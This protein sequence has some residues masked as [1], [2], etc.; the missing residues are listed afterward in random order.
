LSAASDDPCDGDSAHSL[1]PYALSELRTTATDVSVTRPPGRET[2]LIDVLSAVGKSRGTG[3]VTAPV[4]VL[5]I[6]GR[7][8]GLLILDARA[9]ST[10]FTT[11]DG[12]ERALPEGWRLVEVGV[13]DPGLRK[14][15]DGMVGG[16]E[17]Q[18]LFKA[19]PG[20]L[21]QVHFRFEHA[22]SD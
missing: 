14:A 3:I 19:R 1:L 17:R 8:P 20:H 5:E 9:A 18:A 12:I 4:A 15:I 6:D 10:L 13:T 7:L 2:H 11:V 21:Y 16:T 22:L